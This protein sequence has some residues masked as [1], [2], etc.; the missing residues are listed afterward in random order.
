MAEQGLSERERD[1]EKVKDNNAG[2]EQDRS[3]PYENPMNVSDLREQER[4]EPSRDRDSS[5]R[6][7]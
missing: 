3:K 7:R 1:R 6:G 2:P 5:F 4:Y